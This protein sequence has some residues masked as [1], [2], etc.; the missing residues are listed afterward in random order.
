MNITTF[1]AVYVGSYEVSLK[2]LEISAKNGIREID[3][4]RRRVALG[5]EI[6][7]EGRVRIET[8]DELCEVLGE[9][10]QIMKGYRV[11]AYRAYAGAMAK[12]AKNLP[13]LGEQIRMKTGL[14]LEILSNSEKRFISYQSV[15]ARDE[16]DEMA[17]QGA[18]VV[19][20][21]GESVQITLFLEGNLV[22]TQHL[23]FGPVRL[24]EQLLGVRKL[25]AHPEVQLEEMVNKELEVFKAMYMK[26]SSVRHLVLMG[27]YSFELMKKIKKKHSDSIAQTERF[28]KYLKSLEGQSVEDIAEELDLPRAT[29]PLMIPSIV[30]YRCMAQQL[31][32]TQVWVP[33]DNI[34]DGIAYQYAKENK[35]IKQVHDFDEDILSAATHLSKRYRSYSP[36]IDALCS[37]ST[38]IFD[39]IKKVHGLGARDRLLLQ[40]AAI[41]H[42]CGKFVSLANGPECAY[43]IIMASEVIGLSHLE[44]EIVARTV[45]YNTNP[46][47]PYANVADK[48]DIQSYMTAAK[49][50]AILRVSNALDR[51]HKQKFTKIRVS[52][53]EKRLLIT[54]ETDGDII[55]EKGLLEK[56]SDSFESIFGITPVLREKRS[57]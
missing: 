43:D 36:H 9:F 26:K 53:K 19:D 37:M 12:K 54:V 34:G 35:L 20:V 27:D 10:T 11:D 16:F 31:G 39:A 6:Y 44:R 49:L 45:L 1:A 29:D 18:A 15:A 55:L 48:M 42:D 21:G 51:S 52:L 47:E 3:H 14:E 23:V 5:R 17:K 33:G 57:Y 4:I 41:L 13:F 40:V 30:T 50:A 24:Q 8:M 22:T 56:K 46:L 38:Q 25:S 7:K 32:A 2:I 28:V